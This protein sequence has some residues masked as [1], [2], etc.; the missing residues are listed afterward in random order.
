MPYASS[1]AVRPI[2]VQAQ[3]VTVTLT[4]SDTRPVAQSTITFTGRVTL[5]TATP[6]ANRSVSLYLI[7]PSGASIMLAGGTTDS[8]GTFTYS[9]TIPWK[10]S[11]GATT[12]YVPCTTWKARLYDNASGAYSSD[13]SISVAYPTALGM[14]TDKDVY[15]PGERINVTA[16]LVYKNDVSPQNPLQGA[17]ITFQLID[18]STGSVV[19]TKTATTD[20][21]GL[22]STFFTAPSKTGSYRVQATFGGMG[23]AATAAMFR[24]L[25]VSGTRVLLSVA[26]VAT[27]VVLGAIVLKTFM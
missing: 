26:A 16:Q 10:I 8:N 27:A 1:S 19:D 14:T 3:N 17:T 22:A 23:Y 5:D 9:W 6:G 13:V 18:A 25:S 7:H 15:A 2:T 21:N 24:A 4:V 20:A 11:S 12:Y